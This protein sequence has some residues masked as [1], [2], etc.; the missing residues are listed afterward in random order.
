MD[1][2]EEDIETE[3][4]EEREMKFI[5]EEIVDDD[6][7]ARMTMLVTIAL[8]LLEPDDEGILEA[9]QEGRRR[10]NK[11][12]NKSRDFQAANDQVVKDYFSGMDS[13][14]NERD[15]ERRFRVPRSVFNVIHNRL[16]GIDPFIHKTSCTGKKG[17]FPLV[18]MVACFRFLAYGDSYDRDDENLRIAESTLNAIVRLFCNLLVTH[19]GGQY[20]NRCPNVE[21]RKAI[22]E[23]MA[24]RGFPGCMG[25]W[26]C[27]HFNW[28][29][30]PMR[31]AGQ[32]QGHSEGGKKTLI[33]EA[34]ADHRRYIWQANFGDPGSLNDINVLDKSSILGA[35]LTGDMSI[36]TDPYTINGNSRDWMYFLVDGIYPEWSIFVNTYS[37]PID[38]KKRTF[39]KRQE[40]ARK[41]IEC[42]FG[43]L[44]QRFHVLQRP[45]RGWFQ[46]DLVS[47]VHACV[48]L[49]NMVIE[50]KYGSVDEESITNEVP[51]VPSAFALFGR[52]EIALADIA[53]EGLDLFSARMAA[54]DDSIQSC[55]EHYRL[56]NDLVE[57]ISKI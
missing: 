49:H 29:N 33:L 1:P 16:M 31:L 7:E 8:D 11:A 14:Y 27:K 5:I 38:P 34:I 47:I 26:D 30:C 50:A 15:F 4:E 24:S 3:S 39:S 13:I 9:L 10:G 2:D 41:D 32:Y 51:S 57:D 18:K 28:K 42:A 35:L 53:L 25:S 12:P 40:A 20:L 23:A 21:E 52:P 37:N 44:V 54:F 43:V 17:I 56:K 48:I 19:F 22:S 45:L 46:E 36:K 55:Y 6:S